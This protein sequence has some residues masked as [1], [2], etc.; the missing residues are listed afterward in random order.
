MSSSEIIRL[1]KL[2]SLRRSRE[3]TQVSLMSLFH[4]HWCKLLDFPSLPERPSS[5]NKL[6]AFLGALMSSFFCHIRINFTMDKKAIHPENFEEKVIWN[7][8]VWT[9]PFYLIGALYIVAPAMGWLMVIY[10][11]KRFLDQDE[12]TPECQRVRIPVG[13]WV[14]TISMIVML[15]ALWIGH[16]DWNLG[17]SKTIK[18]SVGWAKGWALMAVFPLIGCLNIRPQIIY[19]ATSIVVSPGVNHPACLCCSFLR[20]FASRTLCV[21]FKNCWWP[22]VLSF[23]E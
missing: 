18:S 19:R 16:A 5:P 20:W 13:V 14:W 22:R 15:I 2:F 9:F 4:I 10:L 23:F 6:L 21:A 3:L 11:F 12:T 8:I 7:A 17:L 1:Q